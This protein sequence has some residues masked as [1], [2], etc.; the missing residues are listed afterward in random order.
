MIYFC[1]KCGCETWH[2][3]SKCNRCQINNKD[4]EPFTNSKEIKQ[5]IKNNLIIESNFE[6][7][8]NQQVSLRFKDDDEPFDTSTIFINYDG[9]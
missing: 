4:D 7:Q 3:K 8:S 6:N 2:S 9:K 5:Y 1:E